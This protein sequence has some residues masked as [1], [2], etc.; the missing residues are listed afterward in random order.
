[1]I[2][3]TARHT[4]TTAPRMYVTECTH[5]A[6]MLIAAR[7]TDVDTGE[8]SNSSEEATTPLMHNK[9]RD[10]TRE[11]HTQMDRMPLP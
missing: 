3:E 6:E 7:T 2:P 8:A 4:Q 10:I 9:I 11:H 5:K 1:M